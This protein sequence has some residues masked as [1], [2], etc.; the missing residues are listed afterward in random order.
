[1]QIKEIIID[2]FKSYGTRTVVSGFDKYFNAI[3]GLNGSGKSNIF[4]A[5]CFVMGITSLSHMRASNLNELIYKNGKAGVKK[6]SVT[7][8][9]TNDKETNFLGIDDDEI[10]ITRTIMDGKSKYFINGISAQQ[11]KIK[12]L[13]HSANLNINNP[14]FLIMQGK[15]TKVVNMS[16]SDIL[17]LLEEASGTGIYEAKKESS[18]KT[19]KKKDNKVDE[20]D[21]Y[22]LDVIFPKLEDLKIERNN[23]MKWKEKDNEIKRLWKRIIAH[24]YY[25]LEKLTVNEKDEK[26]NNE[27]QI[28]ELTETIEHIT[29]NL[30]KVEKKINS[31]MKENEN[32]VSTDI[33]KLEEDLQKIKREIKTM[34]SAISNKQK[35]LSSEEDERLNLEV[36]IEN[37]TQEINHLNNK[38]LIL[39]NDLNT[40]EAELEKKRSFLDQ[41]EQQNND[42]KNSSMNKDVVLN[43]L[44][45]FK[46]ELVNTIKKIKIEMNQNDEQN[47]LLVSKIEKLEEEKNSIN[48]SISNNKSTEGE[49]L[50]QKKNVSQELDQLL[51]KHGG[52]EIK[53]KKSSYEQKLFDLDQQKKDIQNKMSDLIG[54]NRNFTLEYNDPERNFDR[55]KILGR[56]YSLISLNEEKY[57][58]ALDKVAGMK[59]FN[60]VVDNNVTSSTL[61]DNKCF[62]FNETFLPLNKIIFNDIDRDKKE[63]IKNIFK[64]DAVLATDILKYDKN[65]ENI[66]KYV[67]GNCYIC[68]NNEVAKKLAYDPDYRVRCVNLEGDKFDPSGS[69][70]GGFSG[71][72]PSNILKAM[73][74]RKLDEKRKIINVE[75]D[76]LMKEFDSIKEILNVIESYNAKLKRLDQDI[77]NCDD[78]NKKS[79]LNAIDKEI[80]VNQKSI[81]T[82]KERK[83]DL[84][85][86]II[87]NEKK[88]QKC[89]EEEKEIQSGKSSDSIIK[90]KIDQL[91]KEI[92]ELEKNLKSKKKEEF[93]INSSIKNLNE[94]IKNIKERLVNDTNDMEDKRQQME[95][96]IKDLDIKNNNLKLIEE[97]LFSKKSE[98]SKKASEIQ[99]NVM[100]K[101]QLTDELNKATESKNITEQKLIEIEQ[102]KVKN[103][104][105]MNKLVMDND[106]I[107]NE[108]KFFNLPDGD[109]DFSSF[110]ITEERNKHR[111]LKDENTIFEKKV[112]KKVDMV[113]DDFEK[114]YEKIK[115]KRDILIKDKKK[116]EETII[117]LDI[118][119]K[120]SIEQVYNFVNEKFNSIYS[121]FLPGASAKLVT[122]D[123]KSILKGLE[124]KVAFN[125]TWKNSLSEL[126]GGQRSLLALSFIL[127]L[128]CYKPAPFYIL[129]EIDAALDLS[130]TSNLGVMIKDHFPQSQFIIISLKDG[131]FNNA[132]V[133]F[134]VSFMEGTSK[135]NRIVKELRNP[136]NLINRTNKDKKYF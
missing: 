14:H 107:N 19:I 62:K 87:E 82:F 133:L 81:E 18:L 65:I 27:N 64:G 112:N 88:I 94:D 52:D 100:K 4:D 117:E 114:Q 135:V 109:Y 21:K 41:L 105:R 42:K 129:D 111:D 78:K 45:Q 36:K 48:K 40:I 15:V 56:V 49:I 121:T 7:L 63:K 10:E 47:K 122:L 128:L 118:K 104:K 32:I 1:M 103:S 101:N 95:K 59:L 55:K 6:A 58:K 2:G 99:E 119:R 98:E 108:K 20:I 93:N 120:E 91:K 134:Q 38:I 35:K 132:N 30:N 29:E 115:E 50:K 125:D 89:S 86:K 51:K 43:N 5:I 28:K 70:T 31:L 83:K 76:N 8:K 84:Q 72:Y 73:E 57:A 77:L 68:S 124:M 13:F 25:H 33:K 3:T 126:S 96:D 106:W 9:L 90:N 110:N 74:L 102:N 17:G 130:H 66:I 75:F 71:N 24:E 80:E 53:N 46:S 136:N 97:K 61:I 39:Q 22:I 34:E 54:N 85:T 116:I 12:N 92:S 123:G 127:S 67:F 113:V 23:Y 131:M 69:L 26:K 79:R 11:D 60:I 44:V 37:N 16:P